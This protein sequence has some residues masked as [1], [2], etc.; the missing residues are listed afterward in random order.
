MVT[1][2]VQLASTLQPLSQA[3]SSAAGHRLQRLKPAFFKSL[4]LPSSLTSAWVHQ[5]VHF[6]VT[7]AQ[8]CWG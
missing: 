2:D 3:V 8:P 1:E 6:L 7:A 5:R 4:H